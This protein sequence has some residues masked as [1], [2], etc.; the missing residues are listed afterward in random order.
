MAAGKHHLVLY[1]S[2]CG[3][4]LG[5]QFE[6]LRFVRSDNHFDLY[7]AR[8]LYDPAQTYEVSAYSFWAVSGK[9]KDYRV[10]SL[11]RKQGGCDHICSI[12]QSGRLWVVCTEEHHA[13]PLMQDPSRLKPSR[14]TTLAGLRSGTAVLDQTFPALPITQTQRCHVIKSQFRRIGPTYA[15]VCKRKN[16][17]I[18][19]KDATEAE[20]ITSQPNSLRKEAKRMRQRD[21][22][23]AKRASFRMSNVTSWGIWYHPASAVY[24]SVQGQYFQVTAQGVRVLRR[25]DNN[26]INGT[27]LLR[28]AG[29]AGFPGLLD[30]QSKDV[31]YTDTAGCCGCSDLKGV[32]IPLERALYLANKLGV[33]KTLYP[34]FEQ[35]KVGNRLRHQYLSGWSHV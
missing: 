13:Q 9:F 33:A 29:L 34:L 15:E 11:K 17:D 1:E 8:A 30:M 28:V 23:A 27:K 18:S 14:S 19:Q 25:V 3:A 7:T 6:L 21:A 20:G 4:I 2:F 24:G 32:W 31:H 35:L 10:R 12:Q 16:Q 22:R 26:L 5:S